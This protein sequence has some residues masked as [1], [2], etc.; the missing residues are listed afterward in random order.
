LGKEKE[1][2]IQNVVLTI[3]FFSFYIM[4]YPFTKLKIVTLRFLYK[5]YNLY[6]RKEKRN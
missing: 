4:K 2:E 1:K 3:F 5:K 6:Y